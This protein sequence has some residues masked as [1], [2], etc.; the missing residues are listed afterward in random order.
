MKSGQTRKTVL[1]ILEVSPSER[2]VR[3]RLEPVRLNYH[4]YKVVD[5]SPEVAHFEE[6]ELP[7]ADFQRFVQGRQLL[8]ARD[9]LEIVKGLT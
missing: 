3:F 1:Y 2:T 5:V 7:V 9:Y 4:D 8:T 6:H